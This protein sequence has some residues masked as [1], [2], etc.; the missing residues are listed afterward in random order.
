MQRSF[1][2]QAIFS[3]RTFA[4]A[5]LALFIALEL[6]L[7]RPYWAMLTVYIVAQPLSGMVRS[8]S[9]Y[10]VIGTAVG[11]AMSVAILP[12]L[13]DTPVLLTLGVAGW[14]ALCLYCSLLDPTPR[15]YAFILA[16]YTTALIVFPAVD[17]P[18]QVFVTAVSRVEEIT[19][20]IVCMTVLTELIFPERVG[21]MVELRADSWFRDLAS[22]A[23]DMLA[24]RDSGN[25]RFNI[26]AR[27][28]ELETLQFHALH[29][30]VALQDT[31]RTFA[32]LQRSM[33]MLI[34]VLSGIR[35]RIRELPTPR[36]EPIRTLIEQVE[37]QLGADAPPA[38]DLAASLQEAARHEPASD[39]TS[40]TR[41]SLL[42]LLG[43]FVVLWDECRGLRAAMTGQANAVPDRSVALESHRDH[44]MAALSATA[45]FVA[46]GLTTAIWIA[47]AWPQGYVAA[48]MAA[49]LCCLFARLDDPA[50]AISGFLMWSNLASLV[51]VA[52][53]FAILPLVTGFVPLV[54]V[55]A[56]T[57]LLLGVGM[58][59]Q[60]HLSWALPIAINSL[61]PL[62]LGPVFTADFASFM[63]AS[64]AQAI[65]IWAALG[66]TRLMRSL[67]VE[68]AL[69]RLRRASR[70]ELAEIASGLRRPDRVW[71]EGRTIGRLGAMGTRLDVATE[72]AVLAELRA[73][74]NVLTLRELAETLPSAASRPVRAVLARLARE[75]RDS[76]SAA[77][78]G[79]LRDRIDAAL[80]RAWG[81]APQVTMALGGLR[82]ALFPDAAPP[83]PSVPIPADP[84]RLQ[85]A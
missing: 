20:G 85:A 23:R 69:Q 18:G 6:D 28:T 51:A 53:L 61:A 49:V 66:V 45:A 10:R 2:R 60:K 25:R 74:L 29:E 75:F 4:A 1:F 31:T 76:T 39:W 35:S 77:P 46:I 42:G 52:Y 64:I 62:A 44:R 43:E 30:N 58:A 79:E 40:A 16:G 22:W 48:E 12:P 83:P 33:Q 38:A 34:P 19:L 27:M 9:M 56:P 81:A 80:R 54:L 24:G 8:K 50:P 59:T 78:S 82:R 68:A 37:A 36:P 7:D 84:E 63:N 57:Y 11:A 17:A 71:L 21:P 13:V 15:S 26:I 14:I 41:R 73:A 32:A 5:I 55:L 65:G 70:T 47:T 3:V 72:I 67:G